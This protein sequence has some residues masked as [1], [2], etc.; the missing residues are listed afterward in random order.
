M[1]RIRIRISWS[2]MNPDPYSKYLGSRFFKKQNKFKSAKDSRKK[3]R[4]DPKHFISILQDKIT[5][6]FIH[7]LDLLLKRWRKNQLT[8][9]LGTLL[10]HLRDLQKSW[11]LAKYRQLS[12]TKR[13]IILY[14]RELLFFFVSLLFTISY[15]WAESFSFQFSIK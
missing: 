3:Y 15:D 13:T 10:R 9:E 8:L 11:T 12:V 2:Y 4:T 7:I 14:R 5:N 1:L 6:N